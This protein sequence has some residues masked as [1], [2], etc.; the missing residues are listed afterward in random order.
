MIQP[1][2]GL[3]SLPQRKV[4]G[5]DHVFLAEHDEQGALHGPRAYPGNGGELRHEV[6][7]GQAAQHL[8][9]QPTIGQPVGA[10]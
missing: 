1:V 3:D 5:Q 7:V 9:V 6:S 4:A 8:L 10:E 2:G